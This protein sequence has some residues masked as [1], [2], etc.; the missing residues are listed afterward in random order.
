MF[1]CERPDHYE[2]EI[3][4][5]TVA[6]NV[7]R[8]AVKAVKLLENLYPRLGPRVGSFLVESCSLLTLGDW[9]ALGRWS[10]FLKHVE[11]SDLERIDATLPWL[12]ARGLSLRARREPRGLAL[13]V[14]SL[15]GLA[16]LTH[17]HSGLPPFSIEQG[18]AGLR[19]WMERVSGCSKDYIEG[20]LL[21]YPEL[22]LDSLHT[23]VERRMDCHIPEA[24]YFHCG[25]PI[26]FLAPE[27]CQHPQIIAHEHSWNTFL[28]EVYQSGLIHHWQEQPD[29][30]QARLARCKAPPYGSRERHRLGLD[31]HVD[32]LGVSGELCSHHLRWLHQH[33]KEALQ[34]V[35][36]AA[37]LN[38]FVEWLNQNHPEG[39]Y[40]PNLLIQWVKNHSD[41][42]LAPAFASKSASW[43]D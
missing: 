36:Q 35:D 31:L 25:Y 1:H 4:P 38:A 41:C 30:R 22:A 5:G 40:H 14:R 10:G 26:Y 11:V 23:P 19:D 39:H 18:W 17:H 12:L 28:A 42:P 21:G 6:P 34:A 3:W 9:R 43:T 27:H 8:D 7:G 32:Y 20:F 15:H 29:F 24:D 37:N 33:E 16:H 13:E 2:A